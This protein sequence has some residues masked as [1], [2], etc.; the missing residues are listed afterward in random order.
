MADDRRAAKQSVL[1]KV[2]SVLATAGLND[3]VWSVRDCDSTLFVLMYKKIV[4]KVRHQHRMPFHCFSLS[5][6][7][8]GLSTAVH[9][10][11]SCLHTRPACV[12]PQHSHSSLSCPCISTSVRGVAPST[13]LPGVAT[14]PTSPEEHAKNFGIVITALGELEDGPSLETS[15]LDATALAEGNLQALN[16]LAGL[17]GELCTAL[18]Q[19]PDDAQR[20]GGSSS[21]AAVPSANSGARPASAIPASKL[22]TSNDELE[23]A[24]APPT[25]EAPDISDPASNAVDSAAKSTAA[26]PAAKPAAKKKSVPSAASAGGGGATGVATAATGGALAASARAA[27]A[28]ACAEALASTVATDGG[29]VAAAGAGRGGVPKRP[30]SARPGTSKPGVH[31]GLTPGGKKVAAMK[32]KGKN[33]S[34]L[35]HLHAI[36]QA[37]AQRGSSSARPRSAAAKSAFASSSAEGGASSSHLEMEIADLQQ[38]ILARESE[39]EATSRLGKLLGDE[40]GAR[41]SSTYAALIKQSLA[42]VRRAEAI[43]V[44]PLVRV[45][46]V[47]SLTCTAHTLLRCKDSCTAPPISKTQ[48]SRSLLLLGLHPQ[49]ARGVA[50]DLNQRRDA[51]IAAIRAQRVGEAVERAESARVARRAVKEELSYRALYTQAL[52][53]ER[54]RLLLQNAT[55]EEARRRTLEATRKYMLAGP[56]ARP[57]ARLN[58]FSS[59]RPFFQ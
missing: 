28:S 21:A 40:Y 59:S 9:L 46:Q 14:Q 38:R 41:A 24:A 6:V 50:R 37:T 33:P 5:Q 3:T 54:E 29:G 57:P 31:G 30:Q 55:S 49:V 13:Q 8:H 34:A 18:L 10:F 39:G 23:S 45:T 52:N 17:F 53:L 42:G 27:C 48:D 35:Q 20:P 25:E 4:G 36:S 56:P 15:G 7:H 58:P 51:R 22:T 19:K 2:N 1:T 26:K 12:S 43:E 44:R 16:D 47:S 32:V 11:A